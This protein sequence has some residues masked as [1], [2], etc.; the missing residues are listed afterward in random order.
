[1]IFICGASRSGTT[2][3]SN[4]LDGHPELSVI[5]NETHILYLRKRYGINYFMRDYL[6]HHDCSIYRSSCDLEKYK[7]NTKKAFGIKD[8]DNILKFDAKFTDKYISNVSDKPKLKDLYNCYSKAL[9]NNHDDDKILVEKRPFDNEICA[10]DIANEIS[11]SKFIHVIRDPRTRYLSV[12]K[13]NIKKKLFLKFIN[14]KSEIPFFILH[15]L[16]S[17]LSLNLALINKSILNERY[18]IIKYEDLCTNSNDTLNKICDFCG[19]KFNETLYNQS[20][21]GSDIVG[22]SSFKDS[23][24][25]IISNLEERIEIYEKN[26]SKMEKKML[27]YFC[28]DIA[29][30]FNYNIEKSKP[31]RTI[32]LFKTC[33]YE[34]LS[35][36]INNRCFIKKKLLG[37]PSY[38]VKESLTHQILQSF[39]T[40]QYITD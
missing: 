17:Y 9:N 4:L 1:M 29:S 32:D 20:H 12:R 24:S 14:Q 16:L 34:L 19:I 40:R 5:P 22:N 26:T 15:P 30:K 39:G 23:S 3:L 13:K 33:K 18:M 25:H 35:L 38:L 6:M 2:L 36:F 10:L 7:Q 11:D 37:V 28:S 8:L 27:Q 31:L 21:S